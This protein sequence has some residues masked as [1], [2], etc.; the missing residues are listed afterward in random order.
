M[1]I[2]ELNQNKRFVG[3]FLLLFGLSLSILGCSKEEDSTPELVADNSTSQPMPSLSPITS[4][5]GAGVS[6]ADGNT[7]S[8]VVLGNG[9]E[10]MASNLKTSKYSNG[11]P[12]TNEVGVIATISIK[13]A[14]NGYKTA[15]YNNVSLIGGNGSGATADI[16]I[17]TLGKATSVSLIT[18]GSGYLSGDILTVND[19][20]LSDT[21]IGCCL[22]IKV[23]TM[24]W[25]NLTFGAWANYNFDSQFE[26]PYGK[27]Y[28]YFVVAD[29]RNVCPTGWHV[30]ND[31]EW[32]TLV[33]YLDP[34]ADTSATGPQ[35]ATAGGRMKSTGKQ[36]WLT[37][38]TYATN[39]S[40]FSALPSGSRSAI[41]NFQ[42][43]YT[44]AGFWTSTEVNTT[45]AYSR[46]LGNGSGFIN[47]HSINK[48]GGLSIR[49]LKN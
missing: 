19:T 20:L 40:G 16:T 34:S 47:R 45:N 22:T 37:P 44:S 32:N 21:A 2:F 11:D 14:G 15:V 31:L 18:A 25:Q 41:G 5:A 1:K 9:Q 7:Y 3:R 12:I 8:S 43:I 6:D 39:E 29:S 23:D 27:L 30:P 36:Y 38:N 17:D 46:D 24:Q 49:C 48:K 35:S 13:T 26:N 28:N 33:I 4:S 42:Y 10:W